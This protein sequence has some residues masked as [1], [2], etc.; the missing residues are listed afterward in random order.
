M[1]LEKIIDAAIKEARQQVL[2]D[3]VEEE[4]ISN[5]LR[6]EEKRKR[7]VDRITNPECK[8]DDQIDQKIAYRILD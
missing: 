2:R 1:G 3:I 7:F 4:I 5:T 6:D 8:L